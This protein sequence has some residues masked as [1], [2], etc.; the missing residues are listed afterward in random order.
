MDTALNIELRKGNPS[1]YKELFVLLYP[2]LKSYCRLFIKE[3]AEVEDLI[4]ETFI[5]LWNKR[6][7][8]RENNSIESL[9]FVMVRNRCLNHLKKVSLEQHRVDLENITINELQYLYQ[10]DFSGK[11]EKSMEEMLIESFREIVGTLPDKM[12]EVFIQCKI[13]GRQQKQVAEE[14]GISLKTIEKHIAQAKYHIRKELIMRHPEMILVIM[15][16]FS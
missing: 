12:K 6:E 5:A 2:R 13:E 14:M 7:N 10:L 15:L 16:Y 3:E 1:A 4:Q 8:V 11:E 9:I